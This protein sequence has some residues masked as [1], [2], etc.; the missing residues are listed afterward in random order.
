MK[1]K[2]AKEKK[3]RQKTW[4]RLIVESGMYFESVMGEYWMGMVFWV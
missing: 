2:K 4:A 3:K 1:L